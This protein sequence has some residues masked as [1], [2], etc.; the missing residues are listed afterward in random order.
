MTAALSVQGPEAPEPVRR[1]LPR[2]LTPFRT[3]AYRKLAI[4]LVLTTFTWG[5]WIVALV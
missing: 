4:A 1:P 5:V 2:A 3:P